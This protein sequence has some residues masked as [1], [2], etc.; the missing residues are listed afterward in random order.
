VVGRGTWLGGTRADDLSGGGGV[1]LLRGEDGG[2]T[3]DGGDGADALFPGLRDNTIDGGTGSD[4][5]H[6]TGLGV[7]AG[8]TVIVADG[9]GTA[10]GAV[11]DIFTS[12]ENVTGTPNADDIQVAWNGVA[13][14]VRGRDG[15]DALST[16]DG[17]TLDT[18]NGGAGINTC[19]NPDPDTAVNC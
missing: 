13:S 16:Q 11:D 6:Y 1:D 7:A 5:L 14:F 17:D 10:T 18:I 15:D 4:T 12:I 8:V 9:D 19:T 3:L 2:D